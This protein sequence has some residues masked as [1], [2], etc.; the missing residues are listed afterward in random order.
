VHCEDHSHRALQAIGLDNNRGGVF[1]ARKIA[2]FALAD[3]LHP[4]GWYVLAAP[5]QISFSPAF[6]RLTQSFSFLF[7]S[8]ISFSYTR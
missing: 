7:F 5:E 2:H 1:E 4:A 3:L 6:L 8:S